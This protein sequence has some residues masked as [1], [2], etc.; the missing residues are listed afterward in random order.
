[1][2]IR[3]RAHTH[4]HTHLVTLGRSVLSE[5]LVSHSTDQDMP[6][7]LWDL[8][9]H[10]VDKNLPLDS[11]LSHLNPIQTFPLHFCSFIFPSVPL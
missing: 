7:T 2:H 1:M 5:K 3:A 6:C 4:T 8:K 11:V 9:D 10:Y